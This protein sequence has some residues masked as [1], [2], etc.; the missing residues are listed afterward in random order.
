MDQQLRAVAVVERHGL[1]H[2]FA[3]LLGAAQPEQHP[4]MGVQVGGIV[5]RQR[6]GPARHGEGLFELPVLDSQEIGIVV[7]HQ[8]IV[9]QELQTAVVGPE[10]CIERPAPGGRR[11]G[12]RRFV[13]GCGTHGHL[14]PRVARQPPD[15]PAE[16]IGIGQPQRRPVGFERRTVA[17]GITQRVA[18]GDVENRTVGEERQGAADVKFDRIGPPQVSL[19]VDD[20]SEVVFLGRRVVGVQL[21]EFER[22]LQLARRDQMA[23]IELHG[24]LVARIADGQHRRQVVE[25]DVE[26]AVETGVGG[27]L[28]EARDLAC[29][30]HGVEGEHAFGHGQHRTEIAAV[31]VVV[32]ERREGGERRRIRFQR[33]AVLGQR[34][35]ILARAG[36]EPGQYHAVG[37]IVG[38]RI[39]H[40][41]GLG[42]GL[43]GLMGGQQQLP[44]HVAQH[45]NPPEAHLGRI[46]SGDSRERLVAQLIESR[47][48]AVVV[49]ILG[50]GLPQVAED[51]QRP[52]V[53]SRIDQRLPV[54]R[55]IPQIGRVDAVG[56]ERQLGR[57]GRRLIDALHGQL[58]I[59]RRERRIGPES[60]REK[61]ARPDRI[62]RYGVLLDALGIEVDAAQRIGPDGRRR[63]ALPGRRNRQEERRTH[64]RYGCRAS[65]RIQSASSNWCRKRTS[66]SK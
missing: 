34:Q 39:D 19:D 18:L 30:G 8:R 44:L 9:G 47:E 13:G 15:H 29:Q 26:F 54:E 35:R 22:L 32:R 53:L 3:R 64:E 7:Q 6:H 5:V 57:L 4:R 16:R 33:L 59:S 11:T 36:V 45:R 12:R 51:P 46:E 1:L 58:V 49:G 14:V 65:H 10:T 66:F 42:H 20:R 56:A 25:L 38:R 60:L 2:D 48:N 17:L 24:L 21:V 31:V 43:V 40:R 63:G 62:A 23:G 55:M 37:G 52:A 28:P 27:K 50:V 61:L 41:T